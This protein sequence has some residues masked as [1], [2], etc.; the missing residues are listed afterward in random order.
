MKEGVITVRFSEFNGKEMID[1]NNG[2]RIGIIG[3]TDLIINP[4]TGEIDGMIL[5]RGTFLSFGK[6]K[7]EIYISWKAI[8]KI[9]PEMII[10]ERRDYFKSY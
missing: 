9:G 8:R 4:E 1:L 2:E 7:D 3:H 10:V 5:P 6:Q